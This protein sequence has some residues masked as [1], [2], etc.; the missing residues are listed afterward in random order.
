MG[1]SALVLDSVTR[2]GVCKATRVRR[3]GRLDGECRPS[4]TKLRVVLGG[5]HDRM[6]REGGWI[7][8]RGIGSWRCGSVHAYTQSAQVALVDRA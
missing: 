4:R 7:A 3:H 5:N 8:E 6:V 2:L 1:P